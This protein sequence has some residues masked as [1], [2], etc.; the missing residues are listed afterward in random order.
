MAKLPGKLPRLPPSPVLLGQRVPA[1]FRPLSFPP[2]AFVA[3]FLVFF[4]IGL[5]G[6]DFEVAL[7]LGLVAGPLMAYAAVGAPFTRGDLARLRAK[8]PKAPPERRPLLFFPAF[9]VAAA[10]LYFALGFVI[11]STPLDEDLLALLALGVALPAAV[12]VGYLLYGFP[13][14]KHHLPSVKGALA[15]IPPGK[16]PLL[17]FPLGLLVAAPV[18]LLL[19]Y[20]LT[21][22]LEA[23][24][25][26]ADAGVLLAL[27][28]GLAV[29]F[30][31][32]HRAV[33][34]PRPSKLVER[35]RV[36][37][38]PAR[39]RPGAFVAFV[40]VVGSLL[41]LAL[42][43]TVGALDAVSVDLAFPL[44]L[45]AG[46]LLAVPLAGRL[47]GYPVP[48][49][50][51]R[52][53]VPRLTR[54]QRPAALLPLTAGLGLVLMFALGMLLGL[55]P[56]GDLEDAALAAALAFPLALLVSLRALR[57]SKAELDPRGL[58]RLP[59]RAR[60][61]VVLALWLFGGTLLYIAAS[62]ALTGFVEAAALSY[63]AGLALALLLVDQPLY[64]GALRARQRRKALA[65][66]IEARLRREMSLEEP[67]PA[68]AGGR[69]GRFRRK[70][71]A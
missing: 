63:A 38:V 57:V 65:E 29:G 51:L 26:L 70:G 44:F 37:E 17:F 39:L 18:Y 40:L 42:G 12:L 47:F 43:G 28:A 1:K 16:R 7:A 4:V 66:D 11:T 33:G 32:A 10:L 46:W 27:A 62:Q 53:Y 64:R 48:G 22:L 50:P 68:A 20:L 36:P 19:G 14:P 61:L 25:A 9:L 69:L 60:P 13:H 71:K 8:V 49:R 30:A 31:V 35:M 56:V 15:R 59:E 52:E 3:G 2:L 45:L 21:E 23:E 55:S 58:Q 5:V 67:A 34:V 41:A 54:E 24:S 6:A